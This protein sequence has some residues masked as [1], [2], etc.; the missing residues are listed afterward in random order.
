MCCNSWGR[1]ESDTTEKL[2]CHFSLSCIGGGNGNPLQCSCLENLRDRGGW[3]DVV[4]GVTQSQT[5]LKQLSSNFG[6]HISDTWVH[7][8]TLLQKLYHFKKSSQIYG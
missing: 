5:Q 1:K 8:K 6:K 7:D 2:H 4:Y 3:W